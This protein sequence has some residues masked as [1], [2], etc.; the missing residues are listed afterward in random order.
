LSK[1]ISKS[2]IFFQTAQL[3]LIVFGYVGFVHFSA[4]AF[5]GWQPLERSAS[6]WARGP[7]ASCHKIAR[8]LSMAEFS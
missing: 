2:A 7:A 5:G 6:G 1:K 8:T 4:D 3:G